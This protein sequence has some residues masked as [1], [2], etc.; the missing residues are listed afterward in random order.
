MTDRDQNLHKERFGK[1]K[2]D[3]SIDILSINRPFP[4]L[5]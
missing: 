2:T 1:H 4:S 5:S 3:K